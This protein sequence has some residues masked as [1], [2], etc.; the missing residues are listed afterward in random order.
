MSGPAKKLG[1]PG[2]EVFLSQLPFSGKDP[3]KS[4]RGLHSKESLP[5][6]NAIEVLLG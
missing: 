1:Q 2:G 3:H 5:T 4:R 6:D